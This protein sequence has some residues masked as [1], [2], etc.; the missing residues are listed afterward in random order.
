MKITCPPGVPVIDINKYNHH[1][2]MSELIQGGVKAVILGFY[3]GN[4]VP[5]TSWPFYK[6][7]LHDNCKRLA[8]QVATSGVPLMGYFYYY[9]K[10]DPV[11]D[12]D[13]YVD[14]M[15]PY[16]VKWA[17][18]DYED[19]MVG[20]TPD[21]RSEQARRFSLQLRSRFPASGVYSAKWYVDGLAPA[22]NIWLPNYKMW[23]AHYRYQPSLKTPMSWEELKANWLPNYDVLASAGML[24]TQLA[25]HQFTGDRAM[26]PGVYD[27]YNRRMPLDV[28]VFKADFIA[29]L[30]SGVL[31]PLPP[32]PPVAT[33]TEYIVLSWALNVRTGPGAGYG[34]A[35]TL[36]Q[37]DTVKVAS[38]IMTN[39][40]VKLTDGNWAY[41]AYLRAK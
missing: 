28:S 2:N 34:L 13:W 33:C 16:P 40:Y 17:W 8:D 7:I 6:Y 14:A 4:W 41:F 10:N 23:I 29:S 5:S 12:A 26:L 39:S 9:V 31:P 11:R 37:G 32:T 38:T 35:Y 1:L 22:M 25:G 24:E 3:K 30:G 20:P 27:Y 18:G 15:Q 36:K 19:I 21:M